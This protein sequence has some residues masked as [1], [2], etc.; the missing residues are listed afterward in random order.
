MKQE[1]ESQRFEKFFKN[2]E[3]LIPN[4]PKDWEK[5]IKPSKYDNPRSKHS[6]S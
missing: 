2:L 1:E 3:R 4:P 5:K 6:S